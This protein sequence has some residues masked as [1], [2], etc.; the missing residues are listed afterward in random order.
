ML[1]VLVVVSVAVV[2]A[3]ATPDGAE[4]SVLAEAGRIEYLHYCAS[5]HGPVGRGDGPVGQTLQSRPT[6][7]TTI[8]AQH[9]GA[10]P[11]GAIAAF[12]DGRT[13]VAA[14]G[15]REMPVWGTRLGE[16]IQPDTAEEV[17]RGRIA[18]LV[19]YLKTIQRP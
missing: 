13:S 7:L 17:T 3:F 8:A 19:E 11:A 1:G 2:P 12:I 16:D 14:H 10:F 15:T 5:C 6:D 9:G 18:F 4:R